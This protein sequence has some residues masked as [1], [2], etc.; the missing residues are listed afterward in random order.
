MNF[1]KKLF[2]SVFSASKGKPP[3]PIESIRR[4]RTRSSIIG[5]TGRTLTNLAT[6]GLIEIDGQE[7]EA[8]S[9]S[10]FLKMDVPIKIVG[11]HMSWLLV[12]AI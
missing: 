1:F 4:F 2:E 11:K 12:E 6:T 7:F 3:S 5:K 9:Q 8:E 10:G